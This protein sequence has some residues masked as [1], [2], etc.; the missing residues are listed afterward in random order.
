MGDTLHGFRVEQVL[1]VP[2][3]HLTAVKL[4][5]TAT[6]AEL[7]HISRVDRNNVF[8]VGFPTTPSDSTGIS[9]ILEHTV[10]CGSRKYPCRDPFF[11]MLT[12]S[13]ATFMNAFTASDYTLYPLSTCNEKDY[14]NLMRVYLDAVFF[15]KLEEMD[16]YQ[17]G[18]RLE[19]ENLDDP[20]SPLVFRGNISRATS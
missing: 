9:H 19:H 20:A 1:P 7:V 17:E 6:G 8:A 12:R 3:F 15:P 13:L 16:F 18:W 2:T 5:H 10:L 14:E 4:C 11:K